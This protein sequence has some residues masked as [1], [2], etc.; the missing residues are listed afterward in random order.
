MKLNWQLAPTVMVQLKFC[1]LRKIWNMTY[2]TLYKTTTLLHF[3][4]ISANVDIN[5]LFCKSRF[6][7][8][9]LWEKLFITLHNG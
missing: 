8:P 9:S 2:F 4:H 7:I 6:F 3:Y 5:S 1:K